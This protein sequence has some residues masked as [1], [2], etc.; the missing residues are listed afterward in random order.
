LIQL[1]DCCFREFQ[2]LTLPA[3]PSAT[4]AHSIFRDSRIAP[5]AG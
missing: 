3:A 5:I 1:G 4:E 2:F